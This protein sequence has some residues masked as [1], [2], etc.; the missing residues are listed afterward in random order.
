[1]SLILSLPIQRSF[2]N[3]RY[4]SLQLDDEQRRKILAEIESDSLASE[5]FKILVKSVM[6]DFYEKGHTVILVSTPL[7][8][9][10]FFNQLMQGPEIVASYEKPFPQGLIFNYRIEP[11]MADSIPIRGFRRCHRCC[12]CGCS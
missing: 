11:K 6:P 4:A 7:N 12:C 5:Q 2:A 1:M 9:Q 10:G 3:A 8:K